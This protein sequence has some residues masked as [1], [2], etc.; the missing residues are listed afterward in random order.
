VKF[1]RSP[2]STFGKGGRRA[3]LGGRFFRSATEANWARYLN[4]LQKLGQIRGWEFETEEFEFPVKRGNR[5][6]KI[7]FKVFQSNGSVVYQEVKGYMDRDSRTKLKRMAQYHPHIRIEVVDS[8]RYQA[9]SKQ[10]KGLIPNW[11]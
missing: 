6:Y 9:V 2:R 10:V 11:E 7:D 8:K 5:F 4:F 1:H 3:D